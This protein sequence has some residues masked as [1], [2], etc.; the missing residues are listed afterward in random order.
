MRY[1]L[2]D[3]QAKKEETPIFKKLKKLDPDKDKQEIKELEKQLK[4]DRDKRKEKKIKEN[5]SL[6]AKSKK[7]PKGVTNATRKP[8]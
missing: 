2:F 5:P 7:D 6:G 3:K 4:D 1:P 8:Q